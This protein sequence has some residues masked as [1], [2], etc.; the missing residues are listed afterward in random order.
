[1]KYR[2]LALLLL[3]FASQA[4]SVP[5]DS[6]QTFIAAGPRADAQRVGN[7]AILA[8][9]SGTRDFYFLETD[10][11]TGGLLVTPTTI[12]ASTGR[13]Y[14]ASVRNDYSS[15]NVT[16]GAW[17]ELIASTAATINALTLFDSCG[18]TLELG[19]GAAAAETRTLLIPP[20]GIDGQFQLTIPSGSRISIRAVSGDCTVGEIAF[21]GFS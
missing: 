5:L 7:S 16:T 3:L 2:I 6:Y 13:S 12:P 1:M 18:E 15:V 10:P 14:V 20:G 17:V 4:N 9:G 11:T 8:R 19:T 21:T